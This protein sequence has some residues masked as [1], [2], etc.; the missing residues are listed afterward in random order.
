LIPDASRVRTALAAV[1]LTASLAVTWANVL[2]GPFLFDDRPAIVENASIRR[3]W[4][5]DALLRPPRDTPVAGRPLV[6]A[7]LA[8]NYALGGL[9]V[10]GYRLL[11]LGVHLACALAL[12][13]LTRRTLRALSWSEPRAR[14]VALAGA[15]LWGVHPLVSEC[16]AYVTQR[17]ESIMALC[18]LLT[19]YAVARG[20]GARRSALWS[21]VAV[22]ACA[23]GMASKET[24]ATAPLVALLYDASYHA[25]SPATALRRRPGL[26]AGLAAGWG[27]LALLALAAPRGGSVG[28]ELGVSAPVYLANQAQ[29]IPAYLW[30]VVWPDPLIFDYGWPQPLELTDVWPQLAALAG[31]G[32]AVLWLAWRR[33]ALG[34]PLLAGMIV[35]VPT[36][37][38]IPIVTEI[39]AERRMY[40]PLASALVLAVACGRSL[41]GR[42]LAPKQ[43]GAVGAVLVLLLVGLLV[44]VTWARSRDYRSAEQIWRTVVEAVPHNPRG[45]LNLGEA[46]RVQ[47]RS[48]EAERLFR[49]ALEL[50][51]FYARAEA[52]LG[53]LAQDRGD[54]AAAEQHLRR[55]LELDPRHGDVRTNLGALLAATGRPGEAL[56]QWR[57]ALARNPEL[58]YAANNLAWL[59]ATHPEARWRDGGEA[60][61]WAERAAR[62]TARSD[63]AVLDTLA[64]A[65]A[66]QGRWEEAEQTAREALALAASSGAPALVRGLRE[67]RA[68]YAARRPY[69]QEQP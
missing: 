22:A 45:F 3:L 23:L 57:D 32:A 56:A 31:L 6:N 38:V 62:L 16:V 25:G 47:G 42:V 58:A 15:L 43:A 48:D 12:F 55:A 8:L 36:S 10:R 52:Q 61:H 1:A 53:R 19:L 64:A 39:G 46:L 40:L 37:S 14:H 59:R 11:N 67:R 68:L 49:H 9:E 54:V 60:L 34:F 13:G 27:V 18:Y 50:Y 24:M 69:R 66:E 65:Y 51:P 63:P 41:L 44:P 4:P 17:T 35:L 21:A 20:A 26:Y 7:T 5:P 33:P 29:V 2:H 28:T 30:R